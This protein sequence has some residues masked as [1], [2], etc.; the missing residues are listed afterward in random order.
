MESKMKIFYIVVESWQ[1]Y[2][3]TMKFDTLEEVNKHIALRE[4]DGYAVNIENIITVEARD[5]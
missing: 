3:Q 2:T 1:G 4:L 5:D